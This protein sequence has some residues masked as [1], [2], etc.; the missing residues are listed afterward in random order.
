MM[1]A[2]D[3]IGES[4]LSKNNALSKNN[5][6]LLRWLMC[7]LNSTK[8]FK[9]VCEGM[10]PKLTPLHDYIVR[11]LRIPSV[12]S[13]IKVVQDQVPRSTLV[14]LSSHWIAS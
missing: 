9:E 10:V 7:T 13:F 8:T 6:P 3:I 12:R 14:V 4:F 1:H 5:S 11:L 2:V